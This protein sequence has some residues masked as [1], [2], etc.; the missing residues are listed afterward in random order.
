[1]ML[2][3]CA[4]FPQSRQKTASG[5]KYSS[6]TDATDSVGIFARVV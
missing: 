4:W 2:D 3:G 6:F 5:V 1:M